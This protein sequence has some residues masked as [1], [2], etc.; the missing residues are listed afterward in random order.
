[1][2]VSHGSGS[3]KGEGHA[4]AGRGGGRR[5]TDGDQV[6]A[7]DA[8]LCSFLRR[9]PTLFASTNEGA[10]WWGPSKPR[11]LSSVPGPPA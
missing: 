8:P 11:W 2:V 3:G 9:I 7:L 1:M 10:L 5:E 6:L 4:G